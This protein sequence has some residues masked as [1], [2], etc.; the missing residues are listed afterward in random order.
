MLGVEHGDRS[1]KMIGK[2]TIG[3]ASEGPI[4]QECV[5]RV[6]KVHNGVAH[7]LNLVNRISQTHH[8]LAVLQGKKRCATCMPGALPLDSHLGPDS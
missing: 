2:S 1:P 6:A 5:V 8:T 3:P 4:G 7:R